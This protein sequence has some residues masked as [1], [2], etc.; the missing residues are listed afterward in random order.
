MTVKRT[1]EHT[2]VPVHIWTEDVTHGAVQQ[3]ENVAHLPFVYPHVA[4]M[5]DAHPGIGGDRWLG[6]PDP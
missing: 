5:P 3:L 6:D 4:A 2:P 1:I